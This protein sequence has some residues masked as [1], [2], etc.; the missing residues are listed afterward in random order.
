VTTD[1]CLEGRHFRR[2]WHTAE[3]A[4]HGAWRGGSLISAA[5]G[6]RPV[7]AFLSLALPKGFDQ[8]WVDGFWRV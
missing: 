5:M 1:L 8:D 4:G 7:A 6:A 3:S 2:D